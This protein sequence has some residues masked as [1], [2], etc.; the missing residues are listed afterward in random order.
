M[1]IYWLEAYILCIK[2]NKEA[3]SVGREKGRPRVFE[4][5]LLRRIFETKREEVTGK[6][7]RLHNEK[8][9][10]LYSNNQIKKNEMGVRP[11]GRRT[12]GK[13]RCRWENN[14]KMDLQDVK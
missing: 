3:V 6:W 8:L 14:I 5:S 1:L 2:K 9:K 7:R 12:L 11:E 13:P 4:N 10:D